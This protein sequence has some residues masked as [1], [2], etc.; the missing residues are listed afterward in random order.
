V[1]LRGGGVQDISSYYAANDRQGDEHG[2]DDT[3]VVERDDRG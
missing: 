3:K 2:H 1:D